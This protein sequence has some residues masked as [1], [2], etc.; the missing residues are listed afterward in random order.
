MANLSPVFKKHVR[1]GASNYYCSAQRYDIHALLSGFVA[2]GA[3]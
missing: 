3:I 2:I 1:N